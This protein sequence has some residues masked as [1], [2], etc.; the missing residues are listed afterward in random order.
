MED[1]NGKK[2]IRILWPIC[3]IPLIIGII[4]LI[5]QSETTSYS[6]DEYWVAQDYHHVYDR[7]SGEIVDYIEDDESC[8]IDG[9]KIIVTKRSAGFVVGGVLVGTFGLATAGLVWGIIENRD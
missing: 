8:E 4:L 6:T 1:D 9:D 2:V 5:T 7:F 3:V